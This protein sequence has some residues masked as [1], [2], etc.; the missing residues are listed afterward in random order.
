MTKC[1]HCHEAIEWGNPFGSS[2]VWGWRTTTGG[3]FTCLDRPKRD[4]MGQPHEA[5]FPDLTDRR[6]LEV[7]LD[8]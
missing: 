6:A 2:G 7:W 5:D 3:K 1:K 4:R 8:E